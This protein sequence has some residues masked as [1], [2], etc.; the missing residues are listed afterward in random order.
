MT[1]V[2]VAQAMSVSC[3]TVERAVVSLFPES[4]RAGVRTNLTAEQV[5]AINKHIH[6]NRQLVNPVEVTTDIEMSEMTVKVIQFHNF[7]L[8]VHNLFYKIRSPQRESHFFHYCLSVKLAI[9][10]WILSYR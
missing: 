5:A 6:S 2:E 3:K 8:P 10:Y 7:F 1:I 9:A 4:I